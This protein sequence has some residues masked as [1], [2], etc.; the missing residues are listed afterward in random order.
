LE[1]CTLKWLPVSSSSVRENRTDVID[2]YFKCLLSLL[3]IYCLRELLGRK[4]FG[5]HSRLANVSPLL[6]SGQGPVRA[7]IGP[8]PASLQRHRLHHAVPLRHPGAY[9]SVVTIELLLRTSFGSLIATKGE[10]FRSWGWPPGKQMNNCPLLWIPV[11]L[12]LSRSEEDN[13]VCIDINIPVFL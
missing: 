5:R 12:Q 13:T 2:V 1:V 11:Y 4:L 9:L 7:Q 3:D 10:Y 6:F 8:R